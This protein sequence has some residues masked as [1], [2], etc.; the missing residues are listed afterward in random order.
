MNK[1]VFLASGNGGNL[2]FFFYAIKKLNLPLEIIGVIA[3]RPCGSIDFANKFR[4]PNYIVNYNKNM[5]SDLEKILIKLKPDIIITN[6]HKILQKSTLKC[7]EANFINLHYS[8][9]PSFAGLIGMKT[10][11]QAK[12]QNCKFIGTT[13]HKVIE[14]VDAGLILC[15]SIISVE[16]EKEDFNKI[17]DT[18]FKSGCMN[19]L[20][21]IMI[22]LNISNE[23]A[24]N[25]IL[26]NGYDVVFNPHLRYDPI[27]FDESFWELIK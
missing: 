27:N 17:V 2:K 3:D 24:K 22:K 10:I 20:N 8:L 4:I 12:N 9:L 21:S 6:I 14:E 19:L 23:L 13:S 5:T 1:I 26:I 7:I 18:V 25:N 15:Q 16:W 11:E